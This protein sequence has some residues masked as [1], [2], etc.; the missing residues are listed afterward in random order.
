MF[1][2]FLSLQNKNEKKNGMGGELM[3]ISETKIGTG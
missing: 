3:I 2:A 1:I